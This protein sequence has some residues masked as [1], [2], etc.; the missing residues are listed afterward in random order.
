M[1][2]RILNN[3]FLKSIV[4]LSSGTIIGQIITFI[5]AP[6][7][8]RLYSPEEIGLY[9]I[10]ITVVSMF[11]GVIV[12]R[13]DMAIVSEKEEEN[14][15]SLI[16]LSIWLSIFSSL[17]IGLFYSI[18]YTVANSQNISFVLF[19][20]SVTLLLF[21]SGI[22]LIITSYNNRM[23]QYEKISAGAISKAFGKELMIILFGL[24]NPT[25]IGLTISQIIG[26]YLNIFKQTTN[27]K[28]IQ[29]RLKVIKFS[30]MKFV[31][32]KYKNQLFFSTPALFAN[33]FSYSSINLFIE[34]LFGA[35]VLG[36]YSI[37]YRVLGIPLTL[38]SNNV[39]KVYYREA[40]IEFNSKGSYR[41]TLL[42]T[43]LLL[44]V[45]A[46]PVVVGLIILSPLVF[47][48]F[49]GEEWS[50][51]GSYVQ[52]LA[53]MFGIRLIVSPLTSGVIIS[54]K[55]AYELAMQSVFIVIS[56]VVFI[57]VRMLNLPVEVYLS[58]ISIGFSIVYVVYYILLFKLSK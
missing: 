16:K 33:S 46:I 42:R 21:L 9:T 53:P 50:V 54:K 34:N 56:L 47:G 23:N 35:S 55:Q 1:M 13:Y 37:S 45:V 6:I 49:F 22:E 24:V 4:T 5:A 20:I 19:F 58:S 40:S 27:L 57:I 15:Y 41:K 2:K 44:T 30:N 25:S 8:T 51:A 17:I 3:S 48:W 31:A 26:K 7:L 39:S 36:F 29:N 14:V 32:K 28:Y 10:L 12:G 43:T 38:I 52:I 18:Y 11:G